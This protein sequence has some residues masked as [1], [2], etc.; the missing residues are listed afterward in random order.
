MKIED[1]NKDLLAES[2]YSYDDQPFIRK[3]IGDKLAKAM[4][5][6]FPLEWGGVRL[7]LKNVRYTPKDYSI[8]EQKKALL[9]DSYLYSP[10]K[11]D[12]YLYN[13]ADN[14]L[15]DAV[16][17]KALL[18]IPYYTQRGTIIH[19]G[20]EYST[21]RQLRLRPGIYSRRKANGEL[22]TQFN[23]ERGTGQGYRVSLDPASGIYKLN[24]GQSSSNLYSILHDMGVSDDQ[25]AEAWGP[26]LLK[27]NKAKYDS[28]ALEKVHS[29]LV[30]TKRS[31]ATN[32]TEMALELKKAFDEQRVDADIKRSNLGL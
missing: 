26:D 22:E 3:S 18:R 17:N 28:R 15:L 4:E 14:T 30:G 23:I 2:T 7:E 16:K 10:L 29:K 9:E 13:S 8:A 25:L 12:L 1:D 5:K 19:N 32:R 6:S 20:N 27:R 21:L 31:T 24:I 11:G